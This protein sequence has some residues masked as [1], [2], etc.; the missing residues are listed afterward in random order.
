MICCYCQQGHPS[1]RCTSLASSST[2]KQILRTSSRFNCL[3]KGHVGHNCRLLGK[4]Q[5]C[6]G[7]HNTALSEMPK[8]PTLTRLNPEAPSYTPTVATKLF[9]YFS[10]VCSLL[11]GDE[12]SRSCILYGLIQI[13]RDVTSCSFFPIVVS[14]F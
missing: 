1:V 3:R 13:V 2:R 8:Y 9:L 10:L 12:C 5:Q 14:S 11:R 7:R 4:C 6:N